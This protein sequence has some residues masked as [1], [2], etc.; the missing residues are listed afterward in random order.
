MNLAKKVK[1]N[2]LENKKH[3]SYKKEKRLFKNHQLDQ[4]R[5]NMLSG[6]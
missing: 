6:K 5:S 4:A 3:Y 2:Q 1:K